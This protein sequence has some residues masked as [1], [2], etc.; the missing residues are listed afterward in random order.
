MQRRTEPSLIKIAGLVR[1]TPVIVMDL[2]FHP[3]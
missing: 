2:M 1:K 3:H